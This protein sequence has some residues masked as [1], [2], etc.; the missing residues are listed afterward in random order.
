[1]IQMR[2]PMLWLFIVTSVVASLI[3]WWFA[4]WWFYVGT[5][6][7]AWPKFKMPWW[8]QV[9]VSSIVGSAV[10]AFAACAACLLRATWRQLV[11]LRGSKG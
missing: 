6:P 4:D 8:G 5:G 2:R 7:D 10:G 3:Y 1:M 11:A 9:V